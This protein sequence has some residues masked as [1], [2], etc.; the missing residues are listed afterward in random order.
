[1]L[2]HGLTSHVDADYSPDMPVLCLGCGGRR[3]TD[4][5]IWL[6]CAEQ[7]G[8]GPATHRHRLVRRAQLGSLWTARELRA[9]SNRPGFRLAWG[10]RHFPARRWA[11]VLS[12]WPHNSD[13]NGV[14]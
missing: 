5:V 8:C 2:I 6:R 13:C 9:P 14:P 10:R 3:S 12:P 1:L 4:E 7:G 11:G